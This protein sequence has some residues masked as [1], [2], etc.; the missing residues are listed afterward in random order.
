ML[1]KVRKEQK[2]GRVERKHHPEKSEDAVLP[3]SHSRLFPHPLTNVMP[4]K[5]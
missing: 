2:L 5:Q 4:T 3:R 1:A